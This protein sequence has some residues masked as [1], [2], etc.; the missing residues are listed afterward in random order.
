MEWLATWPG[1]VSVFIASI[2]LVICVGLIARATRG[3]KRLG[4][5]KLVLEKD[6][7]GHDVARIAESSM[8]SSGEF[9]RAVTEAAR[10]M[11]EEGNHS[12]NRIAIIDALAE[13]QAAILDRSIEVADYAIQTKG[14]NGVVKEAR[15]SIA[16]QRI[17]LRKAMR[18]AP[19]V[20]AV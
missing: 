13:S 7:K 17:A 9:Q 15:D 20:D 12:C 3:W 18:A 6:A 14:V 19:A 16:E 11:R 8:L 5:G 10:I 1:T 2:A 4:L